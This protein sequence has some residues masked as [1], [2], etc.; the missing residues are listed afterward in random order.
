MTSFWRGRRVFLTGHTGFK[1]AWL[2]LWL[3][4]LGA[5]LTGYALA[6]PT[7]PSLFEL[8]RVGE[9]MT[10]VIRDIGDASALRESL[11]EARPEVV[12]HMAAQPLVRASYAEPAETYRVNVMGTVALLDAVRHA[13]GLRALVNVTTDKCYENREWHWGYRENDRLGGFDPYSNSK[14]CSELVTQS[15]RDAFFAPARHAQHGVGVATARAGNVIGGGDWGADRLVPDVVRAFAAGQV[16]R[17]RRPDAI[18]PWQHVLEPLSGYLRLAERLCGDGPRFASGWNF[19]PGD[20]DARPV[21]WVVEELARRWGGGARWEID[22]G[23]H[24]HEAHFLK[25]DI[26]KARADLGWQPRLSLG[27]ALDWTVAWHRAAEPRAVC[28]DQIA[29]Y[30]SLVPA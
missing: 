23:E 24:P 16:A 15:F 25:L 7:Q 4:R 30:E 26:S 3:Q 19:G 18:R 17:I 2:S 9:G 5:Q 29:R 1:G 13:P 12:I 20:A 22:A 6:P 21:R 10:S 8:A 14:A 11:A 27:Q 28:L